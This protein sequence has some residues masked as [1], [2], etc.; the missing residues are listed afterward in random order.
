MTT[1]RIHHR[2]YEIR[3]EDTAYLEELAAI[4]DRKMAEVA[5][6]TPTVDTLKVAVLAALNLADDWLSAEK[7]LE[8]FRQDV[9]ERAQRLL[10][11]LL[12]V[13]A[14]VAR[15]PSSLE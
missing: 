13:E 15:G 8:A 6:Q 14:A 11:R 9:T 12:E 1:V 5:A 3:A 2:E 10:S 4:L 7:K